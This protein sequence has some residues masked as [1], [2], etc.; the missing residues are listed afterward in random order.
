MSVMVIGGGI[1]GLSA[2]LALRQQGIE[3]TVYERADDV[4]AAQLGAGLGLAYNGTR[5]LRKLGLL[6]AVAEAGAR[7]DRFEFCTVEGELLS[8]WGL[9]EGEL[10]L[11]VVRRALHRVLVDAAGD[12]TLVAGKTCVGF[13]E[14]GSSVTASFEDGTTASGS[15]LLGADGL[16]SIVRA[17]LHGE[18]NPRYAG[19]SVLRSLVDLPE[20]DPPL[21]QGLF[22]LLWGKGLSFGQYYVAPGVVYIFGWQPEPEGEHIPRESRREEFLARFRGATPE[23]QELISRTSNESIH[24][25][26]I[27]DRRPID[28]W[29]RGRV[30]L[31]G[32]AAHPMTFNMGQGACQGLE[33]AVVLAR[34]VAREGET[35]A[36]LRAYESERQKRAAGFVRN[37]GRIARMSLMRNPVAVR[38]RNSILKRSAKSLPRAE[39]K[40]MIDF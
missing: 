23:T 7:T 2:A 36:A 12:G 8:E 6:D 27:Y 9:R 24:Q 14:G 37:S 10:Q 26:D 40:L 38:F 32:D 3:A 25:T 20:P 34:A 17:Q 4:A 30:T 16:R 29:G 28:P 33:D 19:F 5:V 15:L 31:A 21:P 1:A 13:Q 11:G 39:G 18:E 22:R 35:P